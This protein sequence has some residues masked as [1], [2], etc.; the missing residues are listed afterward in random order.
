[1]KLKGHHFDSM[2]VIEAESQV[3]L[4]TLIEHDFQDAFKNWQKHWEGCIHTG[5]NCLE[6]DGGH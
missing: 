5:G 3:M 1:M 2:E 4:N 6:G